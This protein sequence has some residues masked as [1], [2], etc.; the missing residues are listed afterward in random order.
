MKNLLFT[1]GTGFLGRNTI[2]TF[3]EKY[4]V[5]TCGIS[6]DDMIKA[7][8]AME[9]PFLDKKYDVVFHACGK[10]HVVP[11]TREEE[12]AF[13]DVNFTGT[14]NLCKALEKAGV[15]ESLIFVST[16]AVYGCGTGEDIDETH[17]LNGSSPYALSKIQAEKYLT[18]WC[19]TYHVRLGIIRPSLIA[20]PNPPGNLGAMISGIKSGKYLSISGG[21]ARKSV[22]MVQ[23]LPILVELLSKHGGIYNVCGD[24]QPTFH[25]LE[26]II[27]EQLGGRRIINVPYWLANICAKV[28]NLLG[29]KAPIN[30]KKLSKITTS[31]TFSNRKAKSELGWDP[32][33]VLRNFKIE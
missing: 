9:I 1:G 33:D 6:K 4:D 11:R 23:D 14:V 21:N 30:S 32:T 18:E 13:F 17:P 22:L 15:P 5:T 19:N 8:L 16:V 27:S 3:K 26:S 24:E 7:N 12:Q 25:E 2:E 10:A 20:G 31:L 29:A 28:G